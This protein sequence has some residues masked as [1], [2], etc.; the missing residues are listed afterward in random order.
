[1]VAVHCER[2]PTSSD[3]ASSEAR[4]A[5]TGAP[6]GVVTTTS[7]PVPPDA[8]QTRIALSLVTCCRYGR[9]AI[10]ALP[11]SVTSVEPHAPGRPGARRSRGGALTSPV[12]RAAT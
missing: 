8:V 2:P 12:P 9:R 3:L 10:T 7:P 4:A 6:A 5:L 11:T 1:M